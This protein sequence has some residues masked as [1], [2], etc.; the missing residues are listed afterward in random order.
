MQPTPH[1][2]HE[3]GTD[4]PFQVWAFDRPRLVASTA[5]AGGGLGL[6]DWVLNATV[7]LDYAR[8]DLNRH[9]DDLAEV[10]G[11]S[12]DGVGLLTAVDVRQHRWAEL[13]GLTATATVGVTDRL[14]TD[15][16]LALPGLTGSVPPPAGTINIV[17]T[18]PIRFDDGALLN[19]VA[20][21]TEAKVAALLDRGIAATGTPTDSVT[22]CC[23][24]E[25][26][27]EPFAG[28]GSPWGSRIGRLVHSV[29]AAGIDDQDQ[30][31]REAER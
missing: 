30:A 11:L 26:A 21:A 28:P 9:V 31:L 27:T 10:A 15:A 3:D 4:L 2:R 6:R 14:R 29:V 18:T 17:V 20:T 7:H 12:G 25:G 22:V 23:P 5:S 1:M 16:N 24:T 13:D 8:T 19:A